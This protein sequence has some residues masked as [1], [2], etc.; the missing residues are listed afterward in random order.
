MQWIQNRH[1]P[2]GLGVCQETVGNFNQRLSA[3]RRKGDSE[4][5]SER[6]RGVHRG[7]VKRASQ[8]AWSIEVTLRH[9]D[10]PEVI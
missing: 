3:V 2:H 8:Y 7:S 4:R 6:V 1:C 5:V 10:Y 9:L